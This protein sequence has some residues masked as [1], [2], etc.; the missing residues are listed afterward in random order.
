MTVLIATRRGVWA[1][2]RVT[3]SGTRFR[4]TRKVVSGDALVAAFCGGNTACAKAMAAVAAGERSPAVLAE[5][6]DGL[7]VTSAGAVWE[8]WS[9]LA[10]RLPS[11]IAYATNGS[12]FAEAQ[13]FLAGAGRCDDRTVRRALAYVA[14]V[15]TDCGD[16]YDHRSI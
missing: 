4:P 12:G 11:K 6:S 16:G 3:G 8:L 2:R 7:L 5:M 1:D 14:R 15:R 9:G 13:A 10:E